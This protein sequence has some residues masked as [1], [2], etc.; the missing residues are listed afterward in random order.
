MR[1]W[2]IYRWIFYD[3]L[4]FSYD[5]WWS[6]TVFLWFPWWKKSPTLNPPAFT[7]PQRLPTLINFAALGHEI[8][9]LDAERQNPGD[10]G[11]FQYGLVWSKGKTMNIYNETMVF[12]FSGEKLWTSTMKPWF[13]K[14][15][16]YKKHQETH[17]FW[18]K[19]TRIKKPCFYFP[20]WLGFPV[21]FPL[22][23]IQ[24]LLSTLERLK[25]WRTCFGCVWVMFQMFI[26]HISRF[27]SIIIS[28][29]LLKLFKEF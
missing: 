12:V 11:L 13:S 22:K 2:P 4:M 20:S 23:P 6:S 1:K 17:S 25:L 10:F 24:W 27:I 7:S 8:Q 19:F 15:Q 3:I 18:R 28:R 14:E 16:V 26:S 9:N 5:I 21:D 29:H